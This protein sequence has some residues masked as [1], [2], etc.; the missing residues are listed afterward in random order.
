MKTVFLHGLGQKAEDW[1]EVIRLAGMQQAECPDLYK[2]T[3]GESTFQ[4]MQRGLEELYKDEAEPFILCGLSLGAI[5][6][7]DYTL[8]HQD[9]V[10]SLILIGAQYKVSTRLI[11]FQ[12]LIFRLL[13]ERAFRSMGASKRDVISL[14]HSMRCLDYSSRLSEITCPCTVI[15]G[16]N[17][18]ANL[19][20]AEE[21]S[22]LLPKA[23]LKIIPEAGHEINKSAPAALA[24]VLTAICRS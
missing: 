9:K 24:E 17:D 3:A 2:L 4:S 6:A 15:C 5:L 8:Q 23:E 13:P 1:N 18:K 11:D 7:L 22:K 16:S 10:S 20:A 19:K 12:N 14:S 21:L